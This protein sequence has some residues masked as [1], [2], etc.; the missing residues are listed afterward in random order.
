MVQSSLLPYVLIL[1]TIIGGFCFF[2]SIANLGIALHLL[3]LTLLFGGIVGVNLGSGALAIPFRDVF[4]VLPLYICV[5]MTSAGPRAVGLIPIDVL[6]SIIFFLMV[7]SVC[8]FN[9]VAAPVAQIVIGLKVWLFYVPFLAVGI[10]LAYQPDRMFR[11]FRQILFWGAIACAVGLLQSMLVRM[12]GYDTA[13]R[14]F[15]GEYASRVTQGF[16]HFD[17]AG[18]IYRIPA[19]FSFV[20]QYGGFLYVYLTIAV[21]ELNA[22]PERQ[23]RRLA[24]I[25]VF[26]AVLA[27]LF[28]GARSLILG[29]PAMLAVYGLFGLFNVRLLLVAPV[30]IVLGAGILALA[31]FDPVA[32]FFLGQQLAAYYAANFIFDQISSALDLGL[33]G[34]GIGVST[35]GAR[36]ALGGTAIDDGPQLFYE[37]YFAKA[38]AELGWLGLAA[39]VV[40]FILIAARVAKTA[41]ANFRRPENAVIAPIAAYLG[42]MIIMSFKGFVLDTDPG[43]IFFWLLFGLMI[44][45]D[46]SRSDVAVVGDASGLAE[47]EA[48]AYELA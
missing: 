28:S 20:G 16:A 32:Y 14:L 9:P 19:T 25:A 34:A 26:I 6:L 18:G 7:I 17:D 45:I 42:Y 43:N 39:I 38:A 11:L 15:F 44:G 35:G 10:V 4:I 47:D 21:I 12:V 24:G 36:Y 37:S 30:G 2:R 8:L 1:G 48:D 40:L 5:F 31:G 41:R 33:I 29:L 3:V 46:R 27:A 23:I 13:I 22:D